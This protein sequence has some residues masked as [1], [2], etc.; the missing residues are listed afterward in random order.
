MQ[1]R[2]IPV[3]Q[4]LPSKQYILPSNYKNIQHNKVLRI[5]NKHNI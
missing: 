1:E 2:K 3:R 5:F 4:K